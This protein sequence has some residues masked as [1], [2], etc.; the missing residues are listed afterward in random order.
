MNRL[1][2]VLWGCIFTGIFMGSVWGQDW[3]VKADEARVGFE[4][5]SIHGTVEGEFKEF[6]ANIR[7]DPSHL[8]GSEI[9]GKIVINSIDTGLGSRDN[10]LRTEKY[11]YPKKYPYITFSSKKIESRGD[12]YVA[13][14]TL[15]MRGESREFELP[16]SFN[17]SRFNASFALKFTEYGVSGG[18]FM[19]K[20]EARVT[21]D[22]PVR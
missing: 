11:F 8:P 13:I 21:L 1:T 19:H 17:G 3:Q 20:D 14:G 7:F 6:Q 9:S 16:F 22:L 18:G 10:S 12:T 5:G 15:S 4:I 2:K